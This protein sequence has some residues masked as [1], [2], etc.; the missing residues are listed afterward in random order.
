MKLSGG[1]G[2]RVAAAAH[3]NTSTSPDGLAARKTHI[4][5]EGIDDALHIVGLNDRLKRWRSQLHEDGDDCHHHQDLSQR[6]PAMSQ[7]SRQFMSA[8]VGME[9]GLISG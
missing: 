4:R 1:S 3:D 9:S 7:H 5:D 8:P 2:L 6:K